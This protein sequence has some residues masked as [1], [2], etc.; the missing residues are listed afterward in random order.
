MIRSGATVAALPQHNR[1]EIMA[2]FLTIV[3]VLE[4]LFGLAAWSGSK[5]A[6]HEILAVLAMGFAF[7]TFGLAGIISEIKA[8]KPSAAQ[9][10]PQSQQATEQ[11]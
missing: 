3:S 10:W 9:A 7:L 11:A 8:L 4:L 2:V 6:I 1:R 5:S